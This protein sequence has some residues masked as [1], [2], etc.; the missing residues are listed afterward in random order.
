MG[1]H[2]RPSKKARKDDGN[3]AAL[4][5]SKDI[6]E[7][8][9]E[10][11]ALPKH[12]LSLLAGS[13][14]DSLALVK[15]QRHAYQERT[16]AFIGE[17]LVAT[18]ACLQKAGA[19]AVE[20]A[21]AA[22]AKVDEMGEQKGSH[23]DAVSK[24][25]AA[26]EMAKKT[27]K[28]DAAAAK[29]A[30]NAL[31][32]VR[33][34]QKKEDAVSEATEATKDQLEAVM[35]EGFAPLK[36]GVLTLKNA[37]L[38]KTA[39]DVT[40]VVAKLKLDPALIECLPSALVK[41]PDVRGTFDVLVL[42]QLEEAVEKH[43]AE[44]ASKIEAAAPAKEARAGEVKAAE[45]VIYT[46]GEKA[47]ASV[48]ALAEAEANLKRDNR[49]RIDAKKEL[50]RLMAECKASEAASKRAAASLKDFQERI[51]VAFGELR[52][53][54]TPPVEVESEEP[55]APT[56]ATAEEAAVVQQ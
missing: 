46:T 3:A 51:L 40:K 14:K 2:G 24:G 17:A 53:R 6:A 39:K 22:K 54:T 43:L 15:D 45:F 28:E 37:G 50:V 31:A 16:V 13:A 49:I 1:G 29:E 18:A 8:L 30:T 38:Q 7:A 26:V 56:G 48:A 21:A 47:K 33:S 10:S 36:D 52:D 35:K 23:D 4:A 20:D 34:A 19:T 9:T 32:Q 42:R 11:T 44:L 12:V 5:K 25:A 55:E 41:K 27:V